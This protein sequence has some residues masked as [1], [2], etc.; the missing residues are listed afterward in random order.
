MDL[1]TGTCHSSTALVLHG[2]IMAMF[3]APLTTASALQVLS[4]EQIQPSAHGYKRRLHSPEH[5]RE[6]PQVDTHR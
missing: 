1:L 2:P 6:H 4:G 3:S 5:F